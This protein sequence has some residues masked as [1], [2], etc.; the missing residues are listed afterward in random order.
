MTGRMIMAATIIP[1][2]SAGPRAPLKAR[3]LIEAC[4]LRRRARYGAPHERR[5]IYLIVA[6]ANRGSHLSRSNVYGALVHRQRRFLDRLGERR[7]RVACPGEI[8]G[9]SAELHDHGRFRDQFANVRPDHVDAEDPVRRRIG[10]H[11]DEPV[12]RPVDLRTPVRSE[13]K[14]ARPTPLLGQCR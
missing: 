3:T 8:F 5:A 4:P 1:M 11:L 7:V 14:F 2:A 13:R 12:R 9:R 6:I 10:Q